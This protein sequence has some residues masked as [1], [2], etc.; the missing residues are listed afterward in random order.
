MSLDCEN[1]EVFFVNFSTPKLIPLES[2]RKVLENAGFQK[3][4][5]K[6]KPLK[7]AVSLASCT[8]LDIDTKQ[9]DKL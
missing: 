4:I 2:V 3:S 9:F 7:I 8:D 6:K 1:G 5:K